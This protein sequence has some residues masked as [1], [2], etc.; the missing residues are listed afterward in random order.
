MATVADVFG[1]AWKLH[2]AGSFSEAEELYRQII[3]LLPDHARAR[4]CLGAVLAQQGKLDEAGTQLERAVQLQPDDASAHSNLGN[5]YLHR[6]HHEA[7]IAH[8]R[9]ALRL[10]PDF[11]DAHNNLGSALEKQG[12]L[13]QAVRHWREAL[14]IRPDFAEPHNNLGNALLLEGKFQEAEAHCRQA[15][16]FRPNFA[17][18]RNNLGIAVRGQGKLDA[19]VDCFQGALE[20]NP[21]FA[22]AYNNLGLVLMFQGKLEEAGRCCNRAVELK[23][24][25]AE[26]HNSIGCI[27]LR[28]GRL[29]LA[30]ESFRQA[31]R[32]R[33]GYPE[34]RKGRALL[35]L[36]QGDF[37]RGWPEF[38]ARWEEPGYVQRPFPQ[39][40]WDGSDLGGRTI[41]LY[42][43]A[44]LGDTF[45][46]I[47]YAPLVKQRGGK[48]IVECQP[49]L[50]WLLAGVTG[51]DHLAAG[52]ANLPAF[53]VQA[54]LLSLPR[55]LHT[56]FATVPAPVPYV[57]AAPELVEHW[58]Q[59]LRKSPKSEVRSPKSEEEVLT[60]DIGHRT[61]DFLVGIAWQGN[62]EYHDDRRRSIPLAQFARLAGVHGVQLISLQKGPGTEQLQGRKEVRPLVL[63]DTAGP[64]VDTAAV[65]MSL[66]LVISSDTAVPHLAGALGIPVWVA[67]PVVGDWRWL[68]GREDSPW[69]P[70]MRLFRQTRP[71]Y[72]EDVFERMAEELTTLSGMRKR[73]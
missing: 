51:I 13:A 59:E 8:Y 12:Q 30:Q 10:H 27:L 69:Y 48:V 62:P 22:E 16:R 14:R 46:F 20:S 63:D 26:A 35:W 73:Q 57:H 61:S 44:G 41:L 1:Q 42:A 53:D 34:A 18:A 40:L 65:M 7:A 54:P 6:G 15:L 49:P 56:A 31:L 3:Q 50:A 55:I 45:Q 60:S 58:R 43:E 38:E 24:G 64:F 32:F 47:R 19:A 11:A 71:E 21:H 28:Q 39:P 66:D 17:E 2:Q 72:W 70:T 23:P 25:F 5:I 37:E 33:P 68:L 52:G 9:Q 29:D 67:L 36:L 4:S